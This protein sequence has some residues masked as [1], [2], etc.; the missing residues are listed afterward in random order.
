[1]RKTAG[2]AGCERYVVI[3]KSGGAFLNTNQS[4][5]GIGILNYGFPGLE[6][7]YLFALTY[8]RVYDGKNFE[9][10]RRGDGDFVDEGVTPIRGASRVLDNFAWPE[11]PGRAITSA[12][13]D[14][15]RALLAKSL[16]RTL[17]EMLSLPD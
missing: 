17:P 4:V 13:R 10:L 16:D 9:V 5:A 1:V 3:E 7:T 11:D 2:S 14:A 12:M 15:T 8:I 6:K